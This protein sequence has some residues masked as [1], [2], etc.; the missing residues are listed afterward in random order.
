MTLL[1]CTPEPNINA[2]LNPESSGET[3]PNVVRAVKFIEVVQQ[4]NAQQRAF[5]GVIKSEQTSPISFKVAGTATK[6]HVTKG[7][8]VAKGE[9]LAS[10]EKNDLEL[11]VEKAKAALGASTAAK[12]Q[13]ED[14]YHRAK[15]LSDKGFVSE[16][17]LKSIEADY[18]AKQQQV[19]SSKADLSNA[20]LNLNRAHLY[21]PFSVST[22]V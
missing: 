17:E 21:A 6:V 2:N 9:I 1:G 12:I 19:S 10:L 7:Q 4:S 18:M 3:T 14:K 8:I 15:K 22:P 11:K 5:N 20:E 13:A 16:S